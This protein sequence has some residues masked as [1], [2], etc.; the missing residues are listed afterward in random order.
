MSPPSS[1]RRRV[2]IF[3]AIVAVCAI[4]AVVAVLVGAG[5]DDGGKA[6][7]NATT[8]L[9][10]AKADGKRTVLYRDLASHGRVEIAPAGATAAGTETTSG[11]RCDRVYFAA[12]RG[13]CVTRGSGFA[14]G[15]RAK[16]FDSALKV[17]ADLP[18]EGIPS[19]ARV[20]PDGRYGA[21]TLFVSGH[22]Y[23][24][25]GTFSTATTIF[26]LQKGTEIADLEK[27]TTYAADGKVVTAEDVNY[28]GVTFDPADSN[29]FYATLATGGKTFLIR[30]SVS[31]RR[32]RVLKENVEC[33]SISPDGTRIAYK[34]RTGSK[35]KPWHLTVLDVAT[36]RETPLAEPRSVD[37]QVEW[38]DDQHVLYGVSD[39]IYM[40]NAD[41]SG[42]PVKYAAGADSPAVVR[43]APES[44]AVRQ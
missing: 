41:G 25:A 35:S 17:T 9:T 12:G 38:L 3:G 5:G 36:L 37:D 23:A 2:A 42:T 28:W 8:A 40:A 26:D 6:S 32:A 1:D 30:G 33:P 34:K 20:S 11:M 39:A 22:A 44:A 43:W 21:T 31:E 10:A 14:A 27:F 16:V 18:V 13:I 24:E 7:A 4:V 19:R 15:Y 29:T